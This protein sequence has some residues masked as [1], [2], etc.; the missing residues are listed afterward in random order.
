MRA[1]PETQRKSYNDFMQYR[2]VLIH[3][4]TFFFT[5]VTYQRMPIFTR[6]EAVET[7]RQACRY[8]LHKHAFRIDAHV[9]LPDHLHM[10]WT[11]PI[12]DSDYPTRWRLI[13]SYFTRHWC[14]QASLPVSESRRSK[15]ERAVWQRRYREHQIRDEDDFNR[16]IEYIHY[17]PVKHG[18]VCSPF[19]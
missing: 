7:L 9:I 17:N 12:W 13:K 1:L 15:G 14:E 11:L 4:V 10:L 16:H 2:R 6:G 3:G 18:F 19:E 8:V 5:V